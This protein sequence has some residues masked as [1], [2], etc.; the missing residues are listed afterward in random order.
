MKTA[1]R[2]SGLFLLVIILQ[3]TSFAQ[4][5]S[6]IAALD[7]YIFDARI[8]WNVPAVSVGIIHND[9]ILLLKGYG[10]REIGTGKTVDENTLF[11]VASNT[12]A[13]TALGLGLLVDEG[14]LRW[15]DKVVD[16]LPWFR[17]YDPYVTANMTV[18]D[19]LTHRSGLA[20]F[21]GDLIWYGSTY[22]SEEII[23]RAA[24]LKPV[25]G[26]RSNYGY[27]NIM[28]LAA[29]EIIKVV[30]GKSWQDF[31]QQRI[32]NPLGMN[33]TLT[34][35][36]QLDLNGNVAIPHNDVDDGLV[37]IKFLNW[38]NIAPAGALLSS[39]GDMLKWLQFQMHHAKIGDSTLVSEKVLHETW[40]SQ[41]V[42]N[43]SPFS[44]QSWP[45]THFKAYGL[46]WA[47]MD[48][49][50][51]KIISHSG[52]YDGMISFSAFVP[53]ENLGFVILT[54]KNSSLFYPLSFKILDAFLSNDTTDW[55]TRFHKLIA[56]N[57][58][59]EK[60]ANDEAK[61]NRIKNTSPTLSLEAYTGKYTSEVYGDVIVELKNKQL[62]LRFVQTP[63][64]HSPLL[65][66]QYNTFTIKFP[67]VP[68]LPEGKA[69]FVLDME[70]HVHQLLIDV[71][72]PDFD[73]TEF[74]FLKTE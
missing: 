8:E 28:Y 60:K 62:N 34:S 42:M 6:K 59:A 52:G 73:F 67:E 33:H 57:E 38:D 32:L 65:H 1:T 55:S 4:Q 15:D 19:L 25:Y 2:L 48:Y 43:V 71:P 49:H 3:I 9:S 37:A 69:A 47:L 27:S 66:W 74:I 70:S 20:T 40:A 50:G 17:L 41:T 12:K 21:S 24:G 72:N 23:R 64:F 10:E 18:R 30:S 35:V 63:M 44:E 54:N 31:I 26:F 39:S 14:K 46:G 61:A 53:E 7:K 51:R 45:S 68:S 5:N 36:T 11:A 13:F 58:A 16:Y 29:G 56:R 22:S